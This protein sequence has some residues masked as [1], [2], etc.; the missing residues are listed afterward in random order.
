M[1]EF[2]LMLLG[3]TSTLK[4]TLV[5]DAAVIFP[6]NNPTIHHIEDVLAE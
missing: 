1:P 2:T 3:F 6:S 5:V 4:V